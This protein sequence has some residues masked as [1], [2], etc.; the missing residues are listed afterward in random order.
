MASQLPQ[1]CNRCRRLKGGH[2]GRFI[3]I[4][5]RC[6]DRRWICNNCLEKPVAVR[7]GRSRPSP[8]ELEARRSILETGYKFV[9]EYELGKFRFDFAVSP[10]R[11]LIEIDSKKW[12]D[13]PSRKARDRRKTEAAKQDGWDLVRVSSKRAE[14]V[15]FLVKQAIS[16]REEELAKPLDY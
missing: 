8:L 15:S 3:K 4:P 6:H 5:G 13:H 1:V 2:L 7:C 11:L 10:L 12:H 16:R 14:S 9:E